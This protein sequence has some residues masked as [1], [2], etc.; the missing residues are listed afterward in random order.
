MPMASAILAKRWPI[1]PRPSRPMVR[2]P[3]S[4]LLCVALSQWPAC[5]R[6]SRATTDLAQ[7]SSRA[8][9]CSATAAALAP[10]AATTSMPRAWAA[11]LSMVSVPLPC[12]EITLSEGAASITAGPTLP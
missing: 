11:T 12:L 5:M 7:A 1:A 3:S 4:R 10:T 6:A 2:P 9:A 8:S